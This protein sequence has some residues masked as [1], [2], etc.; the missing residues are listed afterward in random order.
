M[1]SSVYSGLIS[2]PESV[3]LRGSSGPTIG[4]MVGFSCSVAMGGER[5]GQRERAHSA[6]SWGAA[7]EAL[8]VGTQPV[9]VAP[10]RP[11]PPPAQRGEPHGPYAPVRARRVVSQ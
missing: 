9:M 4:A 1:S 10:E 2:M 11:P 6:R 8:E 5:I 7:P 3:N